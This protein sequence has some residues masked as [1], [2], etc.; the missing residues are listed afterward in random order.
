MNGKQSD[1]T[2]LHHR[3]AFSLALDIIE[4]SFTE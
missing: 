4:A 3:V 2:Q 1:T